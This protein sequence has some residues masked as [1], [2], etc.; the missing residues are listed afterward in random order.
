M[1]P[2]PMTAEQLAGMVAEAIKAY[3]G[4]TP[5]QFK[6][7]SAALNAAKAA[8]DRVERKHTSDILKQT[9]PVAYAKKAAH[10]IR[11][12]KH[13]GAGLKAAAF[14]RVAAF[15]ETT[16]RPVKDVAKS[17]GYDWMAEDIEKA[18]AEQPAIKSLTANAISAGGA[19]VPVEYVDEVIELLRAMAVVRQ[20]GVIEM[21]MRTGTMTL[22]RQSG[23]ASANYVGE[24]VNIASSQPSFEQIQLVQRKLAAI[25]PVSNDLIRQSDPA[26]DQIV[27]DD[28]VRIMAL[29][30]DL[31]FIRG[32]GTANQPKGLLS[33][34]NSSNQFARTQASS[35]QST[36]TEITTDLFTAI[37]NVV[38]ANVKLVRPFWIMHS[39]TGFGLRRLRDSLG[40]L[41][42]DPEMRNGTL[43]GYP[44]YYENQIPTNLTGTNG[45]NAS[46]V[47]FVEGTQAIIADT[48]NMEIDVV[49]NGA[50]YDGSAVQSGIS[51]DLTVIRSISAHDFALRHDKVGS[52][53]TGV[54]WGT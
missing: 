18:E 46:E 53:I 26:I 44:F 15:A 54:D 10:V 7:Q 12:D 37:A 27:R 45:S 11:R 8:S 4:L 36:L 30:E 38:N 13:Q 43:L 24:A 6:E 14:L 40:N 47:Y 28:L 48:L 31:A 22:P 3:T 25:V 16:R 35:P 52:V 42:F 29:R 23:A 32:D 19:V 17:L 2:R 20:A 1:S 33:R 5:E 21:P 9:M 49:P 51:Q 50:Y 39:R 34:I 41:V